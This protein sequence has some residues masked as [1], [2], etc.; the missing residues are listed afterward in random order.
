MVA[1]AVFP[2]VGPVWAHLGHPLEPHDLP[3]AW[4]ADPWL[5]IPLALSALMYRSGVRRLWR[6]GLGRGISRGQAWCFVI[7]W[8]ALA[9]ALVSPLHPMGEVLFSAHMAQHTL[10]I[11]L[12]APLL[13][14]GRPMIPMLWALP[15]S[16][17]RRLGSAAR[18][19]PVRG[20]W[21]TL[22]RPIVAWA[23]HAAAVLAWHA[24]ALYE[25]SIRSGLAHGLQHA[26]FLGTALL[27]WWSLVHGR[28]QR[29]GYGA[30]V[31]YLFTTMLYTGG[32]G[33]LITF[34]PRPWYA[35]Y[36]STA[37]L[38]GL[39]PLEDQQLA[40]LIMWVPAGL[41]YLVAA[42]LVLAAGMREAERRAAGAAN[43][44]SARRAP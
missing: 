38:W 15:M 2:L 44:L 35:A 12:A 14:L 9:T 20:S 1:L 31:I 16:M 28:P 5:V 8:L 43:R 21:R 23:L 42:L 3:G 30:A 36:E 13:I 27:F 26:S 37:M 39:T 32:L 7:G 41:S 40:G 22:T 4:V 11:S 19:T 29:I 33:A 6:N 18:A 34:A 24:P 17:R 10:M 25:A